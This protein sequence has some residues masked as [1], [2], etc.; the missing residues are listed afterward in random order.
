MQIDPMAEKYYGMTPY[1]YCAGNPVRF[2]DPSGMDRYSIDENGVI[3]FIEARDEDYDEL[4]AAGDDTK[5]VVIRDRSV[6]PS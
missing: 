3:I 5:S 4:S 1:H 2:V 6:L